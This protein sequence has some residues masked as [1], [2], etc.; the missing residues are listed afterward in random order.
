MTVLSLK[1]CAIYWF[2]TSV[3]ALTT[4]WFTYKYII[5]DHLVEPFLFLSYQVCYRRES[6]SPNFRFLFLTAC[7]KFPSTRFSI[8]TL[9]LTGS[10]SSRTMDV[11]IRLA[12][13]FI[14]KILRQ[15]H[16]SKVSILL[17]S[18]FFSIHVPAPYRK[19]ENISDLIILFLDSL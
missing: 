11:S 13:Q 7:S 5:S 1:K 10:F 16:I 3:S 15:I 9:S 18:S 12:V 4:E 19:T 8:R 6:T 2:Y 14:F 17:L